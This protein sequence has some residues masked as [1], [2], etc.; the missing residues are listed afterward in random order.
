MAL[1]KEASAAVERVS[2]PGERPHA[3]PANLVTFVICCAGLFG[4]MRPSPDPDSWWH[5]ATGRWIIDHATIPRVD[6]FSWIADGKS[7]VAHE[8]ASEVLFSSIDSWFGPAG[9]LIA[10]GLAVGA[11]LF[12]LRSALRR[13]VSNEWIVAI[14]LIAALYASSLMWSLRPHLISFVLV[15][16]FLE[17]L[18]AYRGGRADR[19]IWILVPVTILW[20]NLHAGFLSGIMLV[21]VFAIVGGVERRKDAGRLLL[22]AALA[23]A[24]GALTPAGPE[25]YVF[26]IYLARVSNQVAEWQPPGIRDPLAFTVT[27]L[28]LGTPAL[29]AFTRKRC[30]AALLTTALVFGFLALGAIRNVWLAGLLVIPALTVALEGTA[31][32]PGPGPS[33]SHETRTLNLARV[34]VLVGGLFFAFSVLSGTESTLRAE[35][36]FPKAAAEEL[37]TLEP[38]RMANPYDWG[39][40]LIWKLPDFP[41]SA[42]GRAD[43]YGE[44]ILEDIQ[45]LERLEPGWRAFLDDRDVKYVLWQEDRPLAQAL[46]LL[47]DWTLVYEDREAVLFQR[48][49]GE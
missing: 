8:W 18:V 42:D 47:D 29:L 26:S 33:S 10:Q 16:V 41:V 22:V 20:A 5:L 7:W 39:G 17:T 1:T 12:V 11:G 49:R 31:W 9:L 27:L 48:A 30:D 37:A 35:A 46:R 13:V 6:P 3:G 2:A 21:W 40:Y 24:A 44:T 4:A 38:G 15:A 45:K 36:P 34:I 19:R 28:V 14:G 43:L 32:I 25:I 23:T